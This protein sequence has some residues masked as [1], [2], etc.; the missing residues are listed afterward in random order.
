MAREPHL[1]VAGHADRGRAEASHRD[2]GLVQRRD[3]GQHGRSE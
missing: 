1:T 2:A 3:A